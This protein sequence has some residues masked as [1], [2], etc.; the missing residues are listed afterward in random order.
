MKKYLIVN[1]NWEVEK[2]CNN[3]KETKKDLVSIVNAETKRFWEWYYKDYEIWSI[4]YDARKFELDLRFY[5]EL[6]AN[7]KKTWDPA[8]YDSWKELGIYDKI[9]NKDFLYNNK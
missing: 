6:Y 2:I 5:G 3:K 7:Y 9:E 4:K 8:E 1:S